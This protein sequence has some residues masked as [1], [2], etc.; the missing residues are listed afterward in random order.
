MSKIL[1][2][3]VVLFFS[4]DRT[5]RI[6]VI[7]T[8]WKTVNSAGFQNSELGRKKLAI[9]ERS[10]EVEYYISVITLFRFFFI[11]KNAEDQKTN[12]WHPNQTFLCWIRI[13]P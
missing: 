11:L 9:L 1:Y 6:E 13:F 2:G 5:Y 8:L 3:K 10:E 12:E 7:Q 4:R